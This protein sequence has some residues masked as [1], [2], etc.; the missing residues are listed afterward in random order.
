[1]SNESEK[2]TRNGKSDGLILSDPM[3]SPKKWALSLLVSCMAVAMVL[4]FASFHWLYT[5]YF[6]FAANEKNFKQRSKEL[7]EELAR[8]KQDVA[9]LIK[10][11]K[12]RFESATNELAMAIQSQEADLQ[13]LKSEKD[14]L[15]DAARQYESVSKA[16]GITND[17]AI[18]MLIENGEV[19]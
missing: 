11:F 8:K 14:S 4:S 1:M 12:E 10:G 13:R 16:V 18:Q 3:G 9:A 19:A 2:E 5:E 15:V 7:D 6:N 17:F